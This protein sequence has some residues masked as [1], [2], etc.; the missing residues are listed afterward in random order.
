MKRTYLA[1]FA[2]YEEDGSLHFDLSALLKDMGQPDT[3]A[4]R[5]QCE[6]WIREFF[7]REMPATRVYRRKD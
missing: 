3:A 5:A 7:G 1:S 6:R 4:N 2:W